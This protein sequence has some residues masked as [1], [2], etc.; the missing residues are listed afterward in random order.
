MAG[1]G[2]LKKR[3][4]GMA[5]WM[6]LLGT[7]F[8]L[9]IAWWYQTNGAV[10]FDLKMSRW[11]AAVRR[12]WLTVG[13]RTVAGL[14]SVVF[15]VSAGLVITAVGIWKR[16]NGEEPITPTDSQIIFTTSNININSYTFN[17]S[18]RKTWY[19][20][21][22]SILQPNIPG[23]WTMFGPF[24]DFIINGPENG[25]IIDEATFKITVSA[26]TPGKNLRYKV[27]YQSEVEV[28]ETNEVGAGA[29]TTIELPFE[30]NWKWWLEVAEYQAGGKIPESI[31]VTE[32]FNLR[33]DRNKS[34]TT[35]RGTLYENEVWWSG[36]HYITGD[37]IVP[38]GL[39]LTIEPG[40]QVIS[41]DNS[42]IK[43]ALIIKGEMTTGTGSSFTP[44]TG[45]IGDWK[46]IIVE[47]KAALEGATISHAER[48]LAALDGAILNITNCTFK[49]NIVGVHAYNSNPSVSGCLFENNV[50]GIKEDEGGRPVVKD[51]R[52]TGNGVDYYHLD[53]TEISLEQLN[54]LPG[55]EGNSNE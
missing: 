53:L 48:G 46:G 4:L 28:L 54:A 39:T 22:R 1:S 13:I 37:V 32:A 35:S 51:C 17:R 41:V 50:Y 19:L 30:A 29:E 45:I 26:R 55:N 12:K 47:G 8:F 5:I 52:F 42:D 3:R 31:V 6:T 14:G 33:Y 23:V 2:V 9:T 40:T 21:V 18:I 34:D 15:L 44:S 20:W 43:P 16:F 7:V 10:G 27:R 38:E 11:M 36:I 25:E 49:N 24:P